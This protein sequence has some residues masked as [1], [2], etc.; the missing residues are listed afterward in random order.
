MQDKQEKEIVLKA[1][2]QAISKAVAVAEII[3]V[4]LISMLTKYFSLIIFQLIFVKRSHNEIQHF[5][6][7]DSR[8]ESPN[9]IKIYQPA[10]RL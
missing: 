8:R 3:K 10:P 2:G 7:C 6:L 1:M 5:N 9:Y 4:L